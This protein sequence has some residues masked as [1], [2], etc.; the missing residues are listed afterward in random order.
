MKP[1]ANRLIGWPRVAFAA[2]DDAD[3]PG[4]GGDPDGD[5]PAT[6]AR[7]LLGKPGL[8]YPVVGH[9]G[10]A[11]VCLLGVPATPA[12]GA[13]GSGLGLARLSPA[14]WYK[15]GRLA[16]PPRQLVV[17]LTQA[18]GFPV[19]DLAAAL[20]AALDGVEVVVSADQTG[21]PVNYTEAMTGLVPFSL[22][23]DD[24]RLQAGRV[25]HVAV[26]TFAA[27][28]PLPSIGPG[29]PGI[30]GD[31]E[32]R[33]VGSGDVAGLPTAGVAAAAL[34]RFDALAARATALK[35]VVVT[36]S[37]SAGF[38]TAA[39]LA[40]WP[41]AERVGRFYGDRIEYADQGFALAPN[42]PAATHEAAA[43][44]VLDRAGPF[45]SA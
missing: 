42:D 12:D 34:A 24:T 28:G 21:N 14:G 39:S 19:D 29:T 8:R 11:S 3:S 36:T 40:A 9:R 25:L 44:F 7:R 43:A 6:D 38:D 30:D 17:T 37:T 31:L 27:P 16:R 32:F 13:T 18:G 15:R 35:K 5:V 22:R 1:A 45:F 2:G 10:S 20:F 41:V 26:W 23:D 4:T 33:D